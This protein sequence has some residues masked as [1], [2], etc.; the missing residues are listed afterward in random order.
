MK[1]RQDIFGLLILTG[2]FLIGTMAVQ[3]CAGREINSYPSSVREGYFFND[4]EN[5]MP[6]INSYKEGK[7]EAQRDLEQGKIKL[8]VKGMPIEGE[9]KLFANIH[10]KYAIELYRIGGCVISA[11]IDGY[12]LGY[13]EVMNSVIEQQYGA[14]FL[15]RI[16]S[17]GN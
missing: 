5:Q 15:E 11:E 7:A 1:L 6:F 3:L 2:T 17:E 16:S 13:N 9:E 14:E 10:K 12:W 8:R 4:K